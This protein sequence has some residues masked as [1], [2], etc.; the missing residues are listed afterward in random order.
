MPRL[1]D[2]QGARERLGGVEVASLERSG[3]TRPTG[4][5][6][7]N[8][9]SRSTIRI[10]GMSTRRR[11]GSSLD[12]LDAARARGPSED[13]RGRCPQLGFSRRKDLLATCDR[14]G[15]RGRVCR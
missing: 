6:R 8:R 4:R 2:F 13:P 1:A 11:P 15:C 9:A 12:V 5:S 3:G 14:V 10:G 7:Q